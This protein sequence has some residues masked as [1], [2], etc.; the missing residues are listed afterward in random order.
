PRRSKYIRN[1]CMAGACRTCRLGTASPSTTS[2]TL[3]VPGASSKRCT[4][5]RWPEPSLLFKERALAQF[6][7]GLLKLRL[8]I[9]HDRPVPRDGLFE[10]FARNKQEPDSIFSGLHHHLVASIKKNE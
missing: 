9:H 2:R 1:P 5:L 3:S 10:W 4:R 7:E 8:R 6:R